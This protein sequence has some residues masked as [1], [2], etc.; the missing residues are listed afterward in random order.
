[1]DLTHF[2]PIQAMVL[3]ILSDV[4]PLVM[5]RVESARVDIT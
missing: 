1:M 4:S 5:C 2:S 3:D